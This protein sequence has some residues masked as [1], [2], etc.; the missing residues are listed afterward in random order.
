MGLACGGA[1]ILAKGIIRFLCTMRDLLSFVHKNTAQH[2][3]GAMQTSEN[4]QNANFAL[5][6]FS[7]VAPR[8]HS[9]FIAHW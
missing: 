7:E 2:R 3:T 9:E 4:P 8:I 1:I 6:E 5:T